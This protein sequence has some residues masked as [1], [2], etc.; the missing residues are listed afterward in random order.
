M[1]AQSPKDPTVMAEAGKWTFDPAMVSPFAGKPQNLKSGLNVWQENRIWH[2]VWIGPA[3]GVTGDSIQKKVSPVVRMKY[4]DANVSFDGGSTPVDA[5]EQ[6]NYV[7]SLELHGMSIPA[8]DRLSQWEIHDDTI[9][10]AFETES[11]FILDISSVEKV[12]AIFIVVLRDVLLDRLCRNRIRLE[13]FISIQN[14][15]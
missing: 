4:V 8:Y 6:L 14:I 12:I 2:V 9:S 11:A 1:L 10:I 15:S 3:Q 13:L 5:V 7:G